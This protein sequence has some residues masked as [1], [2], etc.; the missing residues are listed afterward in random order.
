VHSVGELSAAGRCRSSEI[1][2]QDRDPERANFGDVA[3]HPELVDI[4]G[5]RH[6]RRLIDG[7]ARAERRRLA[8][9]G[10]TDAGESERARDMEGADWLHTNSIDYDAQLDQIVLSVRNLGEV[11]VIDHGTTT[12][13]ATGHSGG[14]RGR[15]GE[16][17]AVQAARVDRG[18]RVRDSHPIETP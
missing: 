10:Y 4:N 5:D 8:A 3:E 17:R 6:R 9:L 18:W 11:W 7:D 16:D 15:G 2:I 14:R 1:P 13:E 12:E